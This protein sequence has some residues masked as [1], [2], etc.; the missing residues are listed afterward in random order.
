MP[1]RKGNITAGICHVL[2]FLLVM[3]SMSG[4]AA[5]MGKRVQPVEEV[6]ET[7]LAKTRLSSPYT[8]DIGGVRADGYQ[9][10]TIL[11]YHDVKDKPRSLMHVSPE[12]FNRQMAYLKDNGYNVISLEHLY[13]FMNL[14]RGLPEKSVIVTFDD[15]WRSVYTKA[16]PILKQYG[17]RATIFVYTDFLRG[18]GA[19]TWDMMNEM[20]DNGMDIQVHSKTH[21][22]KIPWKRKG[23]TEQAYSRRLRNELVM[24]KEM[25]EK[26]IGKPVEF[27]AYPYGQYDVTL[28]E[29]AREYGYNGGLTVFGA[30][31]MNGK[32]ARGRANPVFVHPFE[33]NRVQVLSGTSI[34]K[35]AR[36]LR[37]FKRVD[38]YDGRYDNLFDAQGQ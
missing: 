2:L 3:F 35:F 4:C 34:E 17:F 22:M 27:I 30:T 37:T 10:V 20:S 38:I 14:E 6:L 12:N 13:Q 36:Q 21:E 11:T 16:Y 31:V 29:K 24:P 1:V 15:G 18:K 9:L 32:R 5:L 33:I 7:S 19:L 23:E 8:D 28:I 26:R 25:V